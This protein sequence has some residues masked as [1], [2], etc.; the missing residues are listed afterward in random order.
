MLIPSSFS[1]N[2]FLTVLTLLV[3]DLQVWQRLLKQ[4]FMARRLTA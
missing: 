1:S 2:I 4:A 3:Q